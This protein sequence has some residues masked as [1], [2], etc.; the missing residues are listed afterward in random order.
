MY[1][2]RAIRDGFGLFPTTAESKFWRVGN[3]LLFPCPSL[4]MLW[5]AVGD[6][7]RQPQSV[8]FS[9]EMIDSM[10]CQPHV[11]PENISAFLTSLS[12]GVD[13]SVSTAGI[14]GYKQYF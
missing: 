3:A 14:C 2:L 9:E 12:W 1:L 4:G 5:L 10:V 7:I 8:D 13:R 11:F 6:M